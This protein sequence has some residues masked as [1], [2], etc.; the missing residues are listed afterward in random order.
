MVST[1]T[2]SGA[3]KRQNATDFPSG[4]RRGDNSGTS[5]ARVSLRG[6]LRSEAQELSPPS[7][8]AQA[9][10]QSGAPETTAV[11]DAVPTGGASAR[12]S[13]KTDARRQRLTGSA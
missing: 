7:D 11:P 6:L 12:Q 10:F 13:R 1:Y 5:C 8:R 9:T 4:A 2:P 3:P